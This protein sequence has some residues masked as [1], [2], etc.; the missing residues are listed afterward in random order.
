MWSEAEGGESVRLQS[1]GM[2]L[3]E[4]RCMEVENIARRGGLKGRIKSSGL[5]VLI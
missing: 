5:G 1:V 3:M 4:G 2:S